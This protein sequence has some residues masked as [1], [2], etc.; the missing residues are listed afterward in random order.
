MAC[1]QEKPERQNRPSG[2]TIDQLDQLIVKPEACATGRIENIDCFVN[3]TVA[4]MVPPAV[5]R[6]TPRNRC[7]GVPIGSGSQKLA[8]RTVSAS[9]IARVLCTITD[10]V[11]AASVAEI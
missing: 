2:R 9:G 5:T 8:P 11:S 10:V 7:V 4:E 6:R 3:H 1:K